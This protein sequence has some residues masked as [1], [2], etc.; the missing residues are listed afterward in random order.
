MSNRSNEPAS[1][2]DASP[3]G[4][5]D[6]DVLVTGASGF[7]GGHLTRRL[8]E[9][10]HRVRV[11]VRAES[12]RSAFGDAAAEVVV[13][14]IDDAA[15]VKRAVAGVTHV[16][17]CAGM[18]ADWGPWEGFRKANVE[19]ARTVVEAAGEAGTVRRVL[20]VSTTD[21]YGYPKAPGDESSPLNDI[22]LPYNRS[23]I[24]GER[25]VW[26]AAY[27]T[28]VPVTVVRP[29]SVYGPRSKDFVIEIANLLLQKQMVYVRK[30]AA[31]A[32]L[33]YVDNAVEGMIAAATAEETAGKAYNLRD[34]EQTTWR[35]YVE[36]LAAGI[37]AKS[38]GLSLPSG[39]ATAIATVSEKLYG[40]FRIDSRPVLT[41][42]SVHLLN[43]DQSYGIERAQDDFGLKSP[44]DFEEGMRRTLEWLDSAEGRELVSR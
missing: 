36:A 1:S 17:N 7:I 6:A 3:T 23:K 14:S 43:R 31:P 42:H 29:V 5:P 11:L 20:H 2:E 24:L 12:D 8:A 28:G 35:D 41:R 26:S 21:V 16:Y 25:A 33:L 22:G 13:G 4:V 40:A 30:G 39:V 37:G 34:P 27:H 32:G 44:V 15:A 9:R 38:P 19:G 18:S 10:G